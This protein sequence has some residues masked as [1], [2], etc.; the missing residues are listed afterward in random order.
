MINRSC[1]KYSFQHYEVA[2]TRLS[3]I[4]ANLLTETTGL[5]RKTEISE[6]PSKHRQ[7]A[8]PVPTDAVAFFAG[9]WAGFSAINRHSFPSEEG[10]GRDSYGGWPCHISSLR[11][12]Q[13]GG[14][15]RRVLSSAEGGRGAQEGGSNYRR[16]TS[17][18]VPPSL[19][20]EKTG[21][22]L[23]LYYLASPLNTAPAKEISI[24]LRKPRQVG[25]R[26][27]PRNEYPWQ[28]QILNVVELGQI[29]GP[30]IGSVHT[31]DNHPP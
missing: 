12:R 24:Y 8:T 22:D 1:S 9:K 18:G 19:L 7:H 21:T 20:C 23:N 4:K 17:S 25:A 11:G 16:R 6:I 27:P 2:Y 26:A 15:D 28:I 3:I 14:Q 31:T 13:T 30:S 10:G 5:E 29:S